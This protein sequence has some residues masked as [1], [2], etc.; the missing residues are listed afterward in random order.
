MQKK[1]RFN[2]Y[3]PFEFNLLKKNKYN[4]G[5]FMKKRSYF[6]IILLV[7]MTQLFSY[8]TTEF[9]CLSDDD[10][11]TIL[12]FNLPEYS[13]QTTLYE[14]YQRIEIFKNKEISGN[15]AIGDP[16]VP[17]FSQLVNIPEK[18]KIEYDIEIISQETIKD[19][20][21]IPSQKLL[22]ST[23]ESFGEFQINRELYA[24]DNFFPENIFEVTN[25]SIM[26]DYIF[27][28][29]LV[30][31]FRYNPVKKELII[32]KK[33]KITLNYIYDS[34]GISLKSHGKKSKI[35]NNMA[36]NIVINEVKNNNREEYSNG[37]YL[38]IYN[39]N[40]TILSDIQY[41][42]KWK[43][44]KG[45]VVNILNTSEIGN[46]VNSIKS[47]IQTAYDTWEIPPEFIFILGD[48]TGTYSIPTCYEE[49]GEQ[50]YGD[51]PYT[52]L[53]GDDIFPDAFVG[54]LTFNTREELQTMI[55]KIF[56]YEKNPQSPEEW[57]NNSLLVADWYMSGIS[58]ISTM[59]YI[60]DEMLAF[61]PAM[62]ITKVYEEPLIN[63]MSQSLNNGVGTFFY[64]GFGTFSNWQ[65]Q[66]TEELTNYYKIPIMSA[67]TCYTGP[68]A[69]PTPS[70][71]EEFLRA[72]T[73]ASPK[74]V[75][76]VI[77]SSTATHTCFNNIITAGIGHAVYSLEVSNF[78]AALNFGKLC[79]FNSYPSNP[80][81]Y[82]DWY[83]LG[84]NLLGDPGMELWT[85]VPVELVVDYP[86]EIPVG[87]N[88]INVTVSDLNGS[89]IE[90]AWVTA[91][92]ENDV[93]FTSDYT[94]SAGEVTLFFDGNEML[95][96]DLTVTKKNYLPHLGNFS[97]LNSHSFIGFDQVTELEDFQVS[98]EAS[99]KI[100]LKNNGDYLEENVTAIISTNNEYIEITSED[101]SFENINSGESKTSNDNVILNIS[102]LCPNNENINFDLDISSDSG[103]W[104]VQFCLEVSGPQIEISNIEIL[105]NENFL[106]AGEEAELVLTL[107]NTGSMNY[108]NIVA[109][110]S[111]NNDLLTIIDEDSNFGTI[112]IGEFINNTEDTFIVSASE[113]C[114]AGTE[115]SL[116]LSLNNSDG[117]LL[118]YPFTLVVGEVGINDPTGPD[119]YGYYIFD[120]EDEGFEA[121]PIYNWIEIDPAYGG[122]GI[123]LEMVDNDY[124]GSGDVKV[125]DLPFQFKFY[126]LFY[127]C[128]SI[129]S[130]GF[131]M[132]GDEYSFEWMNWPIP[133]PLV[134]NPLIAPFW[135]DLIITDGHVC[136][137]YDENEQA[138]VIEWS[139]LLSRF[140]NSVQT[141]QAIL[142][143]SEYQQT[144]LGD[145]EIKFQYKEIHNTDSGNYNS[146]EIEHG[147][148]CTIGIID[149]TAEIGLE[150]TYSNEYPI[151]AK[152]LENEMA[153]MVS[154]PVSP[155]QT[156]F[157]VIENIT[158]N[159]IGGNE[160]GIPDYNETIEI[161][162]DLK[163]LGL[164]IAENIEV[165]ISCEN[166]FITIT[167]NNAIVNDLLFNEI[168]SL[169]QPLIMEISENCP[170]KT[171][172]L[173]NLSIEYSNLHKNIE[174]PMQV[175]APEL[176]FIE[177]NITDGNDNQLEP[178]ESG[179]LDILLLKD[180]Y[181]DLEDCQIQIS[182]NFGGISFEPSTFI[183]DTI[184]EDSLHIICDINADDSILNGTNIDIFLD[185]NYNN[186]HTQNTFYYLIGF[187]ELIFSEDFEDPAQ[188]A[189]N[190][191]IIMSEIG[192]DNLAGGTGN[193]A[194]FSYPGMN[195]I[196]DVTNYFQAD[197]VI[198]LKLKFNYRILN[199]GNFRTYVTHEGMT[200]MINNDSQHMDEPN[201]VDCIVEKNMN[202]GNYYLIWTFF[203]SDDTDILAVDNIEI[204]E[205]RQEPGFIEGHVSLD[206]IGDIT[207]VRISNGDNYINPD[208]TGF[209]HLVS[210]PGT[211]SVTASMNGYLTSVA[212]NIIVNGGSGI[213]QD[214]AMEMMTT[215]TN[216]EY[217]L[218]N[219]T[220]FLT[221]EFLNQLIS[222]N[223][224]TRKFRDERNFDLDHFNIYIYWNSFLSTQS[225]LDPE[226]SFD[227]FSSGH[228]RIYVTA[229]STNNEESFHSN[230]LELDLV[231]ENENPEIAPLEFSFS[232]NYPN[233][234]NPKTE[235][236][237]TLPN[238][239]QKCNIAVYN[240]KGK[241]VKQL[242]NSPRNAGYHTVEW[243]G[244]DSYEK[245]V[246]SG[247]YFFKIETD[248]NN[249]VK[250][251]TL[252]K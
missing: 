195:L 162:L 138:M 177:A 186:I 155:P 25:Q 93:I 15:F 136:Y 89:Y 47:Y 123:Q 241:L 120:D 48:V 154:G 38:F 166:E 29:I 202:F 167:Q 58:T 129:S 144:Y 130:N 62:N 188:Q 3:F 111:S 199:G 175:F 66:N 228:Y 124:E 208:Q 98:K 160:N 91:V 82:V 37:S 32:I 225:S 14:D 7:I 113:D 36:K 81:N 42:A 11:S 176:V 128:I 100:S 245:N 159:D 85:K 238:D 207:D 163:N 139:R 121:T 94:N 119:E 117:I 204:Y 67:I 78:A 59:D 101:L 87:L 96:A 9:T 1:V 41:L 200:T 174:L 5:E 112:E 63:N 34:N 153:L 39:G 239:T 193:E 77:G 69:N 26:R 220:M 179:V 12:E 122:T 247:I 215:P 218:E 180:S 22:L 250:R 157:L 219:D 53:E 109:E 23:E 52:L 205:M 231:V 209:Y 86:Q 31:P 235:I 118:E 161:Y 236:Y 230:E 189:Q 103:N 152:N 194:I 251:A 168:G 223:N 240:V 68:F 237:F 76:S 149:Q 75:V 158:Y 28:R 17:I 6:F 156:P 16:D 116:L 57:L 2:T 191:N 19:V 50:V 21:I 183:F 214:F 43:H 44:R 20:N 46:D 211:Y 142:Y 114:L 178:G 104:N 108:E 74:G 106:I 146:Q 56:Y 184:T 84:K 79:L 80:N 197:N 105:N 242:V 10:N 92:S 107:N 97:L 165:E 127:D 135:D 148:F 192:Q 88:S 60:A 181:L 248:K 64:R 217:S 233:P 51:H 126:G 224:Q 27:S 216:L 190:W 171:E 226:F 232:Q 110:I 227:L 73:P 70:F 229:I 198:R 169:S 222:V 141:F 61:N 243:N 95:T 83:T 4:K 173:L 234:F 102:P 24:T 49:Y 147:E 134:P 30:N 99:F 164:S 210:N 72:G 170:N 145:S 182:S 65:P 40:Q 8:Q 45:Y 137:Q 133:G 143:D 35:F 132:L 172:A 115:I 150:Y 221:W 213:I 125:I 71:V 33:I 244:K 131:I 185:M 201:F 212:E 54:R 140:D 203:T 90:N 13:L 252:L 206:G 151:T 249:A 187:Y 18:R 246:S 55:S 196:Y